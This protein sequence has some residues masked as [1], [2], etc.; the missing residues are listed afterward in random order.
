MRLIRIICLLSALTLTAPVWAQSTGEGIEVDY[1]NPKKYIVGGVKVEGNNY[2]APQQIIQITGLQEGMEVTVP[3]EELSAIVKRLWLQRYF[4]DVAVVVDSLAP[5]RDTAFFSR[6]PR[7]RCGIE[8]STDTPSEAA[9]LSGVGRI[10]LL[11][12]RIAFH[13]RIIFPYPTIRKFGLVVVCVDTKRAEQYA[14]MLI[15][16]VLPIHRTN[17]LVKNVHIHSC[18][19]IKEQ[20]KTVLFYTLNT[21][22]Y[23]VCS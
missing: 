9:T 17:R 15:E 3:S 21:A 16:F 5:T 14:L 7:K 6:Y 8:F 13:S 4:E 19:F 22:F 12:F 1:N 20:N 18:I 23:F 2:F 10:S 11:C